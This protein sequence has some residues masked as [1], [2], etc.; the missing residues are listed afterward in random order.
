MI[1]VNKKL[2]TKY[3]FVIFSLFLLPYRILLFSLLLGFTACST[4]NLEDV[5][6]TNQYQDAMARV[7]QAYLKSAEAANYYTLKVKPHREGYQDGT[8]PSA[9]FRPDNVLLKY[10]AL[11]DW[12][13]VHLE[14][15][16]LYELQKDKDVFHAQGQEMAS[17]MLHHRLLNLKPT[18][19]I[20][21]IIGFYT[22]ILLDCKSINWDILVRSMDMLQ[23][24]WSENQINEI[25]QY[26]IKNA[27]ED[28]ANT[29]SNIEK[30]KDFLKTQSPEVLS[31][32]SIQLKE[33]S[34]RLALSKEALRKA[35]EVLS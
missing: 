13:K 27:K 16:Q 11:K 12:K 3:Y 31:V 4:A 17:L 29:E 6:K 5:E 33:E 1:T 20:K 10:P 18:R 28:I 24:H 34:K 15:L 7:A 32:A 8:Y 35:K 25:A 19:E 21:E 2:I 23:G 26:I 9:D 14:Y 30:T 22:R